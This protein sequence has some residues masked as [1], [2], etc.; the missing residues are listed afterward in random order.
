MQNQEA[1][2]A[3]SQV[4]ATDVEHGAGRQTNNA[5]Q[6]CGELN[7]QPLNGEACVHWL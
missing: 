4:A 3:S 6:R 1:K 2:I 7:L 5:L